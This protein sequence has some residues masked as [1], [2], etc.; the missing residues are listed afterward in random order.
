M[1]RVR[2][3]WPQPEKVLGPDIGIS[4]PTLAIDSS[5]GLA[6]GLEILDL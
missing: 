3:R 1:E 4:G 5:L 6:N 2:A